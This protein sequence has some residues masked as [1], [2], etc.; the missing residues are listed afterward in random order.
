M[1]GSF[2]CCLLLACT[3][4]C[5]TLALNR[6]S[7]LQTSSAVDVRYRE[8]MENLA[9][10]KADPLKLPAFS[11]IYSGTTNIADTVPVNLNNSASISK[12][13]APLTY[14]FSMDYPLSRA[15]TQNWTL[16]PTIAPEKLRAM[17]CAYSWVL[18]GPNCQCGDC[19]SLENYAEGAPPG[20]YFNV[21][22]QL[23][24]IP[25]GWIHSGRKC[26]VPKGAYYAA[27]CGDVYVWVMPQ[28]MEY[29]TS[30]FLVI[31][32][33]ARVS[34]D[35]VLY[36]KVNTSKIV[37]DLSKYAN[38]PLENDS[39]GPA[40]T[41]MKKEW[42]DLYSKDD[43]RRIGKVT[44]YVDQYGWVTPGAGLPAVPR[45]ARLDNVGT[46]SDLKSAILAAIKGP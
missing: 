20:Y 1:R 15:V 23:L 33:I 46:A 30:F 2:L 19:S 22:N 5:T 11:S 32:E 36:P 40:P 6:Q 34:D 43:V 38:G 24:A 18:F 10:L 12:A 14:A 39:T 25:P 4:G 17:R 35:S 8:V 42:G 37:L 27:N 28:D 44:V 31:Q 13:G 41:E 9:M 29:L 7:L 21:A 16:D 45:K 3:N 26:N